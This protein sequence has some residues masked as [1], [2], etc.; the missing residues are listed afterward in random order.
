MNT[1]DTLKKKV[2]AQLIMRLHKA[3][4][5][6]IFEAKEYLQNI[7]DSQQEILVSTAE[8]FA[9]G[10]IHDPVELD[11]LFISVIDQIKADAR[12]LF[13]ASHK[14]EHPAFIIQR[15]LNDRYNIDWKTPFQL[16]P[17]VFWPLY[18]FNQVLDLSPSFLF[19]PSLISSPDTPDK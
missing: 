12:Q 5:M 13:L 9:D 2:P 8:L 15:L 14:R 19:P 6:L 11:P 7:P 1:Q 17:H 16:N 3:V 4:G 10:L 18:L